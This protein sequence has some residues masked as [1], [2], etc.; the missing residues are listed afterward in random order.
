MGTT[1]GLLIYDPIARKFEKTLGDRKGESFFNNSSLVQVYEDSRGLLWVSTREGINIYDRRNDMIISPV[2][3]LNQSIIHGITEDN[4]KNMWVTSSQGLYH[5]VVNSDPT[6][7]EYTF[8][9][10]KYNDFSILDDFDFNPRAILRHSS[11]TIVTGGVNGISLID[12]SNLKYDTS[13]PQVHFTSMQ[14]FNRDVK[15]DSIYDGQRILDMAPDFTE[16]IHLNHDQNVFSIYQ[17]CSG[18]IHSESKSCEQ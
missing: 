16:A 5:I 11:G 13:T 18:R 2:S 3:Q 8:S 12:P 15:I 14:L 7:Q 17:P 9:H 4:D 1:Y 6:T 10:R